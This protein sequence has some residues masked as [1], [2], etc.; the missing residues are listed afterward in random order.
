MAYYKSS[1]IKVDN[2]TIRYNANGELIGSGTGGGGDA[3]ID[4]V[5]PSSTTTYSSN[6]I[7]SLLEE[8]E[9]EIEETMGGNVLSYTDTLSVLGIPPSPFYQYRLVVPVMT[10]N[11]SDYGTASA[12]TEATGY[13]AYK[14][15][16]RSHTSGGW[17]NS[18]GVSS[19]SWIRFQ[20]AE[21]K[22]IGRVDTYNLPDQENTACKRFIFQA[23][24]NGT[25]W[26]DLK[27][28]DI[29]SSDLAAYSM[30][31]IENSTAYRYYRVYVSQGYN[32]AIV[33]FGQVD[34]F[35]KY[36]A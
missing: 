5:T 6:K 25:S 19:N 20:F 35:E 27:T 14:A 26:T 10:S 16:R 36:L 12:S 7:N 33:G 32:D 2:T 13:E 15:F 28:C 4:D 18:N 24:N 17:M 23:S 34:Y 8:L 11:T 9:E 22:I 31:E 3:S 29:E 30:F 1:N 21:P